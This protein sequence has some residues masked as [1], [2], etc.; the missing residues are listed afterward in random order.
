[1]ERIN[2][3]ELGKPSGFSHAVAAQGRLVF[4]AGQTALDSDNRIVGDGVVEQFERALGNLLT[5][6]RAAGGEPSD[7]CG[8]TVYIVDMDDYQ[9]HAREIGRV[10]KRLVGA[11][12]PAMAGIGVHRLWDVEALV[13]VQGYAVV[14][15]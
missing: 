7:L 11:D 8:L 5:A 14:N 1:M 12:Y 10:W 4:L 3:P 15:R 9:A 13:E 6:L 2:P